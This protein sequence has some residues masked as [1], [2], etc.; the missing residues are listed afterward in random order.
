MGNEAEVDV[1][2]ESDGARFSAAAPAAG[3]AVVDP[4]ISFKY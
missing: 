1:D 4:D 2:V 3:A